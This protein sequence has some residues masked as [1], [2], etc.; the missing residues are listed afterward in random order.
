MVGDISASAS[1]SAASATGAQEAKFA[2]V[3]IGTVAGWSTGGGG[4]STWMIVAVAGVVLLVGVWL[5]M[6]RRK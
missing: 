1:S 4:T 3:T 2:P 5:L 6:R